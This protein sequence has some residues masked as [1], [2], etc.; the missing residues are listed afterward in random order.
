MFKKDFEYTDYN[1]N[2]KTATYWF[3]L[4][5]DEM[6]KL[7]IGNYGGLENTMKRMLDEKEPGKVLDLMEDII[8]SAVGEVSP[9]GESFYKNE[10]IRNDFKQTK[11]CHD[12]LF[13]LMSNQDALRNFILGAIPSDLSARIM[14]EEAKEVSSGAVTPL[15]VAGEAAKGNADH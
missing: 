5:K 12:L 9:N 11:V 1:G 7:E 6:L 4:E 15:S 10:K 2:K 3:S 13:E 8:L 14:E